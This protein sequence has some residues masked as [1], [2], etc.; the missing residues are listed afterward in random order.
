VGRNAQR[1]YGVKC[2]WWVF[3]PAKRPT[4]RVY[5]SV[6]RKSSTQKGYRNGW[7]SDKWRAWG[8]GDGDIC[9]EWEKKNAG[10]RPVSDYFNCSKETKRK[11]TYDSGD[12]SCEDEEWQ[13]ASPAKNWPSAKSVTSGHTRGGA[14]MVLLF[15]VSELWFW[16]DH[17][18]L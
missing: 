5:Y 12:S 7:Q 2:P 15:Y 3:Y 1:L 11:A 13:T 8:N 16:Q 17:C 9:H 4:R 10:R 14:L 6:H 18:V